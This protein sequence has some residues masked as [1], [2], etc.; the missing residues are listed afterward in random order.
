MSAKPLDRETAAD[1]PTAYGIRPVDAV[2][3]G[4]SSQ[5]LSVVVPA[6]NEATGI[7][8]AVAVIAHALA[9]CAMDFEIIV[10]DDGSHDGTFERVRE[11]TRDDRRIKGI[12]F[13]RNFGKEAAL[14]AGLR[15][16]RG[17]VVVTI[18][19][20]LQHPPQ[21]IP[22]MVDAWRGGAMVVDAV[23]RGRENDGVL[24]RARAALFNSL[25]S[26]LSGINLQHAS[27]FKLLDRRVVDA[28]T[29]DLPER[30]RFYRGISHWVG[31][32]HVSVPFDVAPRAEG[33]GKW[34]L[35]KLAD[36]A[37]TAIVSF[38]S[39]PL[40]IVTIM[41]ML[42]LVFG[43]AVGTEALVGWLRGR[44]ISGFTTT[45]TTLLIIGSFI[46]ISLGII[47]EYIAKIYD[48]IKARPTYLVESV[49]TSDDDELPR[50]A[51]P[52]REQQTPAV[53]QS[54]L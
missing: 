28:I 54:D 51:E 23:K 49:S 35:W 29:R 43:F 14:L 1:A 18:D 42:T 34:T 8:H 47:G 9:P 10:V 24:T 17:D 19:S 7:E 25:L 20:D 15:A 3:R 38:T 2:V 46:M 11:L 16:A 50:D 44:A 5:M 12:R 21:L 52:N 22:T 33:R 31:F 39:A 36:L 26:R 6:H 41:G 4:H 32:R 13:T 37:T 27:D 30:Q 45:I 48:E 40:R 53:R